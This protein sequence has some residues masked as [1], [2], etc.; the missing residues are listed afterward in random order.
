M[1]LTVLC[2]NSQLVNQN[3]NAFWGGGAVLRDNMILFG[4]AKDC[5]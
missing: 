1:V 5:F 2:V 3:P 4:H